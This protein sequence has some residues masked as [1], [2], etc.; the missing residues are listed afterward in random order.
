MGTL[1][2]QPLPPN[3]QNFKYP[4]VALSI[5]QALFIPVHIP[6]TIEAYHPAF[7]CPLCRTYADSEMSM[8]KRMNN[9]T[10]QGTQPGVMQWDSPSA[11]R[12][13]DERCIHHRLSFH[14]LLLTLHQTLPI[15]SILST[16][17]APPMPTLFS[18]AGSSSHANPSSRLLP[19]SEHGT[20]TEVEPDSVP[21]RLSKGNKPGV[22]GIHCPGGRRRMSH[23][24]TLP[25]RNLLS[26]VNDA[27]IVGP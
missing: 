19:I 21:P 1:R 11:E 25:S 27:H 3:L 22:D 17:S 8:E 7:S 4:I 15:R 12:C 9:R 24:S 6:S 20:D 23:A 26:P 2:P 13:R 16:R 10:G 14:I 18:C 5:R